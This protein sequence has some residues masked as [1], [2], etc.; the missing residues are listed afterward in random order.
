VV[1]ME[2]SSHALSLNR[3]EDIQFAGG[4]FTNISQ[5]HLDFYSTIDN[6]VDA[7]LKLFRKILKTGFRLSNIDDYYSDKFNATGDAHL[8]TYSIASQADFTWKTD[9]KYKTGIE[10]TITSRNISVPIKS[11]MSGYY[12]LSNI[13]A[14]SASAI[15]LGIQPLIISQAIASVDYIPGRLQEIR[16]QG[17]PR[18]FIDYAHTPDAIVNVL[19]ALKDIVPSGGKLV[20]V[21]GCGGNRDKTKRPKMA[22]AAASLS[23]SVIITTDNPRF[24]DPETIIEDAVR[25]FDKN[26][27]YIKIIDRKTAIQFAIENSSTKDIVAILGKGHENYQEING[28]RHPFSDVKIVEELFGK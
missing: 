16:K 7:K 11:S 27:N 4:V 24:E 23:D 20:A 10:G 17:F 9:I 22:E 21:F 19:R 13:L 1:V 25:G 15:Q 14:A 18:V 28:V 2:V 8:F 26:E 3:A 5:D 6:Y 12:N